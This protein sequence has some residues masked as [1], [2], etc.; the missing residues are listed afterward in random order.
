[1]PAKKYKVTLTKE[2][3]ELLRRNIKQG[4]I[5]KKYQNSLEIPLFRGVLW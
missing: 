4:E 2:E 1:M 5:C 3:R